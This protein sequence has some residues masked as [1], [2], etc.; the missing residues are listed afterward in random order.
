[1]DKLEKGIAVSWCS[2]VGFSQQSDC[3]DLLL[4]RLMNCVLNELAME[5][6]SRNLS[7]KFMI[8]SDLSQI[9]MDHCLK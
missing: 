1:M 9:Y 4:L 3:S 8:D 7:L 2:R 6:V 5:T